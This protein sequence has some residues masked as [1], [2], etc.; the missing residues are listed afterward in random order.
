[1]LMSSYYVVCRHVMEGDSNAK[2]IHT[3]PAGPDLVGTLVC[4]GCLKADFNS[5][6]RPPSE[7]LLLVSATSVSTQIAAAKAVA[8]NLH[9]EKGFAHKSV[10]RISA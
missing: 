2:V 9:S 10:S 5:L 7:T 1:M 4:E 3:D 8:R 6:Q